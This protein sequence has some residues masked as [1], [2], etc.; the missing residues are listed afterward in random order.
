M[1][2]CMPR[3]LARPHLE[4]VIDWTKRSVFEAF[5]SKLGNTFHHF[6]INKKKITEWVVNYGFQKFS[7]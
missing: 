6:Q 7:V 1:N 4:R 5:R 3:K 2:K